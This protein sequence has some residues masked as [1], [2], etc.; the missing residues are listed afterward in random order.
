MLNR[1]VMVWVCG[2]GMSGMS[3][4]SLSQAA[5][6]QSHLNQAPLHPHQPYA[7]S[8][9]HDKGSTLSEMLELEKK[10]ATPHARFG[11]SA[12][13]LDDVAPNRVLA[14]YGVGRSLSAEVEFEGQRYRFR[15]GQAKPI[16]MTQPT[17]HDVPT[18]MRIQAPCVKLKHQGH[19]HQLCLEASLP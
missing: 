7:H 1:N 3:Q 10:I 8:L 6:N 17:H 13:Y 5:I 15:K 4:M 16:D 11:T 18:L 12:S 9:S 2:L 14:I 19:V